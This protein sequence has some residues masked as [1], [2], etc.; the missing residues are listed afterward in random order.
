[1]NT[2]T[3]PGVRSLIRLA[4]E[5]D[6]SLGD[7]TSEF[8]F[9]PEDK[10]F[11]EVHAKQ[12][13][14]VC[15]LPIIQEIITCAQAQIAVNPLVPE[16][17]VVKKGVVLA[18]L[19]GGARELLA[20]ERTILNFLQRLS[21]V[22]T[23][24]RSIVDQAAG[25]T[26]LDT[27]KTL[28]GWRALDK[29]AVRV[30]GGKNHRACLGDLIMV[31]NNHL[32]AFGVRDKELAERFFTRLNKA[33][34]WPTPIEVEVRDLEELETILPFSPNFI[35]LDNMNDKEVASCLT[36]IAQEAFPPTVEVSGGLTSER[37][38]ALAACGVKFASLGR[39][40]T[41][42]VNVDISM[43]VYCRSIAL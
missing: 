34:A 12:E 22:A 17:K 42:A 40:T 13:L 15:G 4:L 20:L 33:K 7:P 19:E 43:R 35:M 2:F 30:G 28:P 41:H 9:S 38:A 36:R 27:R 23:Y 29:Y 5:E 10:A 3:R 25:I 1:M 31:K 18:R 39:L 14:T 11:A 8:L 16:G 24:T 26:V 21:G 32:D 37:F 6:L